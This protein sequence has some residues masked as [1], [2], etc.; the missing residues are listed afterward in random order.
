MLDEMEA[1]LDTYN[2]DVVYLR[3][4]RLN[5][6]NVTFLLNSNFVMKQSMFLH[7]KHSCTIF[8]YIQYKLKINQGNAA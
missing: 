7:T 8:E 4:R 1:M 2:K 3:K 6:P 5:M